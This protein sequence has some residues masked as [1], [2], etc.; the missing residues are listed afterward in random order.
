[1]AL[2]GLVFQHLAAW[3]DYSG[4]QGGLYFWRTHL[5]REVDFVVYTENEFA[6]I[7]VKHTRN[8]SKADFGGLELFSKD[9]PAARRILLYRG[10]EQ[11]LKDGVLVMPVERFLLS[12]KPGQHLPK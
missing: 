6:A 8:P 1:M 7:E 12:L 5:G 11:Y 4:L 2:E 9:Y 3:R 10:C